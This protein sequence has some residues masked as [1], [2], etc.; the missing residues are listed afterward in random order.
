MDFNLWFPS[1]KEAEILLKNSRR[2]VAPSHLLGT[3]HLLSIL[4]SSLC[5]LEFTF[6][7][8]FEDLQIW[9]VLAS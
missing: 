8:V 5:L 6:T 9:E 3:L 4:F 7:Q 2:Y 1:K